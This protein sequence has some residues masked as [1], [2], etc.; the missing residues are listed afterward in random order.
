MVLSAIQLVRFC[1]CV[2][3][4][5]RVAGK[6]RRRRNGS[7]KL[8]YSTVESRRDSMK[9]MRSVVDGDGDGNYEFGRHATRKLQEFIDLE[10]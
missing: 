1:V 3:A 7:I 6:E 5:R 10:K 8:D 4:I 9:L 2:L